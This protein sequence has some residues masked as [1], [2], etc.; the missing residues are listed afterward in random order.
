[1]ARER[2]VLARFTVPLSAARPLNARPYVTPPGVMRERT[3]PIAKLSEEG[4]GAAKRAHLGKGFTAPG[5]E[6][7]PGEEGLSI[8]FRGY[9]QRKHDIVVHC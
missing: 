7:I 1:M 6:R 4:G 9:F 3:G 8:M 2:T 5:K